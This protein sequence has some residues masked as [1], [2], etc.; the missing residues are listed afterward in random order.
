VQCVVPESS[1]VVLAVDFLGA[2][3]FSSFLGVL[4]LGMGF[5][6]AISNQYIGFKNGRTCLILA[7]RFRS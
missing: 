5:Y 3:I 6:A 7:L 2:I 4:S 1:F